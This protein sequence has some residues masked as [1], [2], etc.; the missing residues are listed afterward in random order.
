[1]LH[2]LALAAWWPCFRPPEREIAPSGLPDN[3]RTYSSPSGATALGY[4]HLLDNHAVIHDQIAAN[5]AVLCDR[6]AGLDTASLAAQA[7]HNGSKISALAT[8][9]EAD[10]KVAA[11]AAELTVQA[12]PLLAA[13]RER[14]RRRSSTASSCRRCRRSSTATSTP[15]KRSSAHA[16]SCDVNTTGQRAAET[17]PSLAD[18][19]VRS[20]LSTVRPRST[21]R[22]RLGSPGL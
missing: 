12:E 21:P 17:A 11:A 3:L 15:S 1:M 6:V 5:H 8:Q 9:A 18:L 4:Q 7:D 10:A 2:R 13:I 22:T 20:T 19:G 16:P 14:G